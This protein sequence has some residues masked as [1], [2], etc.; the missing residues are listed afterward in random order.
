[1]K[2]PNGNAYTGGRKNVLYCLPFGSLFPVEVPW[3][4]DEDVC[5][6]VYFHASYHTNISIVS[7][8]MSLITRLLQSDEEVQR[9]RCL[10]AVT[11]YS[12]AVFAPSICSLVT[13]SLLVYLFSV[14]SSTSSTDHG[15]YLLRRNFARQT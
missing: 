10:F 12:C 5:I 13:H 7:M 6:S 4:Y 1:M 8:F 9:L 3:C 11:A 15:G 14:G 2:H